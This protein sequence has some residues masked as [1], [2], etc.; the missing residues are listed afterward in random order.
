MEHGPAVWNICRLLSLFPQ[1]NSSAD[2]TDAADERVFR[3]KPSSG[4]FTLPG[5]GRSSL[6]PACLQ[7]VICANLRH[8]RI[9]GLS[10]KRVTSR[11]A[12]AQ[13]LNFVNKRVAD[14]L[15]FQVR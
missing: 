1:L 2:F 10:G 12:T 14:D 15:Q 11:H 3:R 7:K 5:E 9:P 6:Q 8:L 4:C 13:P